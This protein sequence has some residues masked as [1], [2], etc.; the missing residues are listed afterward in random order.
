MSKSH[1]RKSVPIA[2]ALFA[3]FITSGCGDNRHAGFS[4]GRPDAPS[5]DASPVPPPFEHI[6]QTEWPLKSRI[7]DGKIYFE[8]AK[9]PGV[10]LFERENCDS[11]E[12][13]CQ[14]EMV[15]EE[16]V[17]TDGTKYFSWDFEQRNF[18]PKFYFKLGR[19]FSKTVTWTDPGRPTSITFQVFFYGHNRLSYSRNIGQATSYTFEHLDPARL[20]WTITIYDLN[21][22][23]S[24][25]STSSEG[26]WQYEVDKFEI[27]TE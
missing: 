2:I 25:P 23:A 9:Q 3:Q 8:W 16:R 6:V 18:F 17:T 13:H 12:P 20:P 15:H 11:P 21:R 5:P 7:E 4:G 27:T 10:F 26:K 19:T 14:W 22:D 24:A 1:L